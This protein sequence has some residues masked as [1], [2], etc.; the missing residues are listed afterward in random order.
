[1]LLG[2]LVRLL[3]VAVLTRLIWKFVRNFFSGLQ[4]QKREQPER[5]TALVRDPVCGTYV[6]Q[7]RALKIH[8][9]GAVNYFCSESCR[10]EF[11]SST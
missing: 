8:S 3:L 2:W 5:N 9:D 7:S 10:Q 1:M 6:Q 11:K 4:D